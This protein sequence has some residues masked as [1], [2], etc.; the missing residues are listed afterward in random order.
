MNMQLISPGDCTWERG[1]RILAAKAWTGT[2]KY[3]STGHSVPLREAK[4]LPYGDT[5]HFLSCSNTWIVASMES[6]T[7]TMWYFSTN[8][9]SASSG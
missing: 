1:A 9:M 7:L 3:R 2:F 8:R 6:T 4:S 5:V